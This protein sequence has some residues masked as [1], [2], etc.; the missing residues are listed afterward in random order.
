MLGVFAHNRPLHTSTHV[1]SNW[2]E[3]IRTLVSWRQGFRHPLGKVCM[4]WF[5]Q[6]C[7]PLA[8]RWPQVWLLFKF[9]A[10]FSMKN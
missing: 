1:S 4:G 5:V 8:L 2:G 3:P 10:E 9:N 6:I 7:L